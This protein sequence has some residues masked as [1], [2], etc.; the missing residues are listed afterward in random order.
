MIAR[1]KKV[2]LVNKVDGNNSKIKNDENVRNRQSKSKTE[3]DTFFVFIN[4][5]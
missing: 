1:K 5:D 2:T 3:N 4:L